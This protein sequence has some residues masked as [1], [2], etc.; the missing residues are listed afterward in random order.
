MSESEFGLESV[1]SGLFRTDPHCA[2]DLIAEDLTV[3]D[4]AGICGLLDRVDDFFL[5]FFGRDNNLEF[6]LR[7]KEKVN[8]GSADDLF[9]SAL[10]AASHDLSHG[11]T[12][13]LDLV[14]VGS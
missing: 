11:D 6:D 7:L 1:V 12:V 4:L 10:Y 14:E 13:Y 5:P 3:S 9:V 8:L 2:A